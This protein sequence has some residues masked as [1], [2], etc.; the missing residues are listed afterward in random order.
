M[1]YAINATKDGWRAVNSQDDLLPGE[2]FSETQPVLATDNAALVVA[3]LA[4]VRSVR[5]AMLNR[6]T[7]I[8]LAAQLSGDSATV[9]GFQ[10]ARQRLLDITTGCPTD[11]AQV[12]DFIK[13]KYAAILSA[14]PATMVKAFAGV[15]A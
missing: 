2:T 4:E 14:L 1:T 11:P 5:E 7:G 6:M 8:A 3:K 12:D 10:T 9:S 13:G 15:D